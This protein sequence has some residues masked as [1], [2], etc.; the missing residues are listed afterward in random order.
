MIDTYLSRC[1]SMSN[2][3]GQH[4]NDAYGILINMKNS[5]L[6][7]Y[8]QGISKSMT[9]N[10]RL[11]SRAKNQA[12][13]ISIM[14]T[15]I[16]MLV[17]SLIVLGFAQISRREQRQSL[18]RQLSSQ[19]FFAA[20]S[21]V[22]DARKVI[23]TAVANG[24]PIVEK[25]ECS[26]KATDVNYPFNPEI[27]PGVSYPCLLVTSKLN[28]IHISPLTAGGDSV[29]VPLVPDSKPIETL[30]INWTTL[31]TPT[32]DISSCEGNVKS[33]D[34]FP[35]NAGNAWKCP[36]GVLRMDM[37]PTDDLS[38]AATVAGQKTIFL[39]PTKG[40][41]GASVR[42]V[43]SNG[44]VTGMKCKTSGCDFDIS[45]MTASG[46]R[47]Y[48]LRLSAI[49]VTGTVDITAKDASGANLKLS[50]AQAEIDVTGKAQ[51]V[52]RRI[53]V[54]LALTPSNNAPDYSIE[55]GS[56]IC[57]RFSI[58][59]SYFQIPPDINGQDTKNPMCN[60]LTV[61]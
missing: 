54:R 48:A 8:R 13:M 57:K 41:G 7:N 36:Y 44:A 6:S 27:S 17:I 16:M 43:D 24:I 10:P 2:Q 18:D 53:Q 30:H 14:V 49:Y 20:E 45:M 9:R 58:A 60:P 12:G 40:G 46:S 3:H 11:R 1:S 31:T 29:V 32:P 15:M 4:D 33:K 5:R 61:Q 51:D 35:A 25:T 22:N 55:S 28:N 19:A 38:R 56:S 37:V 59:P 52:L 42:Y 26:T 21:G 23:T 39:Y 47:T 34:T 50:N